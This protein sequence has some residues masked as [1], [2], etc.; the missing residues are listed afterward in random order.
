VTVSQGV[1][2]HA[3]PDGRVP[4]GEL[5]RL[6]GRIGSTSFGGPAAHLAVM[7]TEVVGRRGWLS[8]AEFLDLIAAAN[9]IPGPNST[10]V[11]LHIG[12]RMA[13][14]AGLL[15]AGFSFIAPAFVAILAAAV[16]YTRFGR[17]LEASW[18]LAGVTPVMLAIMLDALAQ[19]G[20]TA[21]RS[22]ARA[23]LVAVAALGVASGLHELLVLA[24][25]A[26]V[27]PSWHLARR[28]ALPCML[29]VCAGASAGTV[30]AAA[31]G[32]AATVPV[33]LPALT[34]FFLKVGSVLFG[35]G[36]VLFAFL[37]ADLVERWG[38]LTTQQLLDAIAVSQIMP[39]P[40]FAT[41]AFIGY[42][43]G[44]LSG[45]V[46]SAA[47]IFAPAF[48]LV[49]LTSP[50]I[51]LMRSS[52]AFSALLDGIVLA[53]LGLMAATVGSIGLTALTSPARLA[54]CLGALALVWWKRPGTTWLVAGGAALG[55]ATGGL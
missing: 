27:W 41:A 22:A 53:S 18:V 14:T 19:F 40:F 3:A 28:A 8:D 48:V 20:R 10:E 5:A 1:T 45:A 39:G 54:V 17:T 42:Q 23:L 7:R 52:A 37:H 2:S 43:L 26:I 51:G 33:T 44:G 21:V 29:G 55:W 16:A 11:A 35:S 49:A 12:K 13:G 25:G 46:L 6:F 9:L 36:Y 32:A 38:W 4:L 31:A 50:F 15:V 24:I 47:G 34:L 30:L